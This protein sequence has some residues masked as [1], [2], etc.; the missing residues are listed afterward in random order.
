LFIK[1]NDEE[2]QQDGLGHT[3]SQQSIS[4]PK[5]NFTNFA[6]TDLNSKYCKSNSQF[7]FIFLGSKVIRLV[8]AKQATK[9][10][11]SLDTLIEVVQKELLRVNGQT[12]SNSP[13]SSPPPSHYSQTRATTSSK[14][15]QQQTRSIISTVL[16]SS[17]SSSLT[18]QSN[19]SFKTTRKRINHHHLNNTKR[20]TSNRNRNKSFNHE[21]LT[22]EID[23]I[24]E[25]ELYQN[26]HEQQQQQSNEVIN[27]SQSSSTVENIEEIV[28]DTVDKL[29]AI[30]LLNNAPFIVNMITGTP[31]NTTNTNIETKPLINPSNTNVKDYFRKY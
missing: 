17:H 20:M 4:T 16:P 14:Q 6:N 15:F 8:R 19:Q 31:G 22:D 30:T 5:Q 7:S 9:R 29:V 3:I 23:L 11:S 21:D 26:H 28:R 2:I 13:P 27:T 18:S 24:D 10:K 1:D 25:D 12:N